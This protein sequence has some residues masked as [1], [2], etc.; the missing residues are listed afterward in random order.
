MGGLSTFMGFAIIAST[1]YP[2]LSSAVVGA[3]VG[4]FI[5]VKNFKDDTSA[6]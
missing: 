2:G 5:G 3:V 1:I 6:D 4:T